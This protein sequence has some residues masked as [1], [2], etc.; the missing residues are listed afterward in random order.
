MSLRLQAR[1]LEYWD[2]DPDPWYNTHQKRQ[3]GSQDGGALDPNCVQNE[4]GIFCTYSAEQV[5]SYEDQKGDDAKLGEGCVEL[6]DGG[7]VC[8]YPGVGV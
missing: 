5:A 3:T 1:S 8:E 7:V 4:K 2:T 6:D